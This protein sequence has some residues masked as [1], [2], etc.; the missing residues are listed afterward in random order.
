M[1]P[2]KARLRRAT[3][4]QPGYRRRKLGRGFSYFRP[5]GR[6]LKNRRE[7]AR[8][9]A[10]AIPPAWS[11]V[12]ICA[13]ASGHIQAT[14]RDARGRKQYRYHP[15]W[16]HVRAIN[17]YHRMAV[18]ARAL[19]DIRQRVRA[20]L[21]LKGLP[22]ERSLAAVIRLLDLTLIRVGNSEYARDNNS[23]GLTT[24]RRKHVTVRGPVITLRFTGKGRKHH[25]LEV[26]DPQLALVMKDCLTLPGAEVFKF[27]NGNGR[28]CDVTAADA[29]EY[30]RRLGDGPFTAKDFRTWAATMTVVRELLR[31]RPVA[32]QR[33][34]KERLLA[35]IDVAAHQL[36]NTRA[37]CRKSYVHPAIAGVWLATGDLASNVA[38]GRPGRSEAAV[39]SVISRLLRRRP[40]PGKP[41]SPPP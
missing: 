28:V 31:S 15:E 39:R 23:F 33:E 19:P 38:G 22:R 4:R 3:D 6:P 20:H 34:R 2:R 25:D 26:R 27:V 40:G 29:N 14:G 17:K 37:I 30:L 5:D 10:L 21:A 13:E 9:R 8:I 36:N 24:L 1:K 12:W 16:E 11:D 18:F 35:A 41:T 32:T 7:L